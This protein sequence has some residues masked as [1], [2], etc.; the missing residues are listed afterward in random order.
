WMAERWL[1]PQP[2]TNA[3]PESRPWTWRLADVR[4]H[5]GR[6]AY[7]DEQ[8]AQPVRLQLDRI[9]LPLQDVQPPGPQ[10]TEGPLSLKL[11]AAAANGRASGNLSTEGRLRLPGPEGRR[12]DLGWRGQVQI[13]RFPV[14]ALEPYLAEQLNLELLRADTSARG[15]V[16][17]TM[18]Q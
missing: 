18:L 13:E 8:P 10:A 7:L 5:G 3:D 17:L 16:E 15:Q 11:R 1:K 4:V 14:H 12:P 6:V 2:A 9:D